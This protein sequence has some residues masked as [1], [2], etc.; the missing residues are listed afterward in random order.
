MNDDAK[1]YQE[2]RFELIRFATALVGPDDAQD[3]VS[4]VVGRALERR[5]G[6]PGLHQPLPYLMKSVLNEAR[7]IHRRSRVI[8]M[9]PL[10]AAAEPSITDAPDDL[11]QL[12]L[13]LPPRQRAATF[14]VYWEQNTPTE[15]ARLMKCRPAT[16][17]R[18]LYL[19]RRKLKESL[20]G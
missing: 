9:M 14:L 10:E 6:L 16:V 11:L 13:G 5:G 1:I 7:T 8:K 18:Y 3:L 15:A 4:I 2:L 19:A 20:D 12:V 17:R